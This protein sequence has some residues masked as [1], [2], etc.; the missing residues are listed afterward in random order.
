MYNI[1]YIVGGTVIANGVDHLLLSYSHISHVVLYQSEQVYV[2]TN[3]VILH[4]QA[5]IKQ[6]L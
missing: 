6:Y 3:L 2:S 5:S 1:V 4:L